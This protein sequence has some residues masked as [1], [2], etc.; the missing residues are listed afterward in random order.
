M[1]R[2]VPYAALRTIAIALDLI[3]ELQVPLPQALIW[4]ARL[5]GGGSPARGVR[6]EIALDL[7]ALDRRLLD[8]LAYAVEVAPVPRRGRPPKG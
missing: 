6:I 4:G 5:S 8:R 7:E 3:T 1:S 2:T